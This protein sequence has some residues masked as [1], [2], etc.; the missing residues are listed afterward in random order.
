[1]GPSLIGWSLIE[2]AS[3]SLFALDRP[4]LPV[5]AAAVPVLVN[6]ALTM[7]WYSSRPEL[8]GVPAS[9][10]LMAGFL[11]LFLLMH[12]NRKRWLAQP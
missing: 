11:L 9:L 8:L 2:I 12:V 10:G 5:V 3:R 7:Y 6:V 4:W 1:M